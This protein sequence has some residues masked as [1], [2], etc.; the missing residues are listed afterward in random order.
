VPVAIVQLERVEG[1]LTGVVGDERVDLVL[2]VP[3]SRAGIRGTTPASM[4]SSAGYR[5]S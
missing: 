1:V 4:A 3:N 5:S 2:D